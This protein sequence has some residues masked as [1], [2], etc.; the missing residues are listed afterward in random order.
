MKRNLMLKIMG[1]LVTV[2]TYSTLTNL[3]AKTLTGGQDIS[4]ASWKVTAKK[5]VTDY[6]W[7]KADIGAFLD[8]VTDNQEITSSVG[9][10]RFLDVDSDGQ[11]ELVATV[12]F[13]GRAFFNTLYIVR[14]EKK[15]FRVQEIK[16]WN[17]FSLAD[18]IEDIDGD[19]HME[20][21]TRQ[22]LTP[23]L[24]AAPQA[25]WK[26]VYSLNGSEYE[27]RSAAFASYY[28]KSVLNQMAQKTLL[29][30]D[31]EEDS[32]SSDIAQIE[33]DKTLRITG[34]DPKAGLAVALAWSQ[35]NIPMRRI[36][37]VAVLRE[38]NDPMAS[39]AIER[40]TRDPDS[41]V[42]ANANIALETLRRSE[43][44]RMQ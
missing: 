20:L 28:E 42:A 39:E 36:F 2:L 3:S 21:I 9:D 17:M 26:A 19:G 12:D 31:T 35:D 6:S 25:L 37:A 22:S 24:G 33:L 7:G 30:Q 11:I 27:D 43:K 16:V 5:R 8:K 10:F 15:K 4:S 29:V 40:L 13:S 38:I 32:F 18:A 44:S 1:I 14:Q 34:H 23:Y 41:D